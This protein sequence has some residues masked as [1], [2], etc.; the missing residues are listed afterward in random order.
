MKDLPRNRCLA[1]ARVLASI[2]CGEEDVWYRLTQRQRE[3]WCES[4]YKALK[5]A[6]DWDH[7]NA[8]SKGAPLG[9]GSSLSVGI[10][11]VWI[12]VVPCKTGGQASVLKAL[13]LPKLVT[14]IKLTTSAETP[15]NCT[16][17]NVWVGERG[18]GLKEILCIPVDKDE[19]SVMMP[20]VCAWKEFT[21]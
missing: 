20:A 1:A 3:N 15:E 12:G 16:I 13:S 9:E 7:E 18:A 11:P 14:S 8:A 19:F 4:A 6:E 5:A 17:V 21:E 10:A 2:Y